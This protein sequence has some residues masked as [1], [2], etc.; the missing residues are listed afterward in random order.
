MCLDWLILIMSS[1]SFHMTFIFL[2]ILRILYY[3][4]FEYHVV[5]NSLKGHA[6][7]V[8]IFKCLNICEDIAVF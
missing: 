7:V 2:F 5:K 6:A 8:L 3:L 4:N 1:I